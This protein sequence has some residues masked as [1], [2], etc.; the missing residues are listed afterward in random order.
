MTNDVRLGTVQQ[1][2]N[3]GNHNAF[4]DL[5]YFKD[6]YYLTFRNCPDGHMLYTTSRIMVL[7]STDAKSWQVVHAFNVPDRDVR[8]P[9]FLLF[10]D[11]LFVCS[12]TWLVDPKDPHAR[13]MNE[14]QGYW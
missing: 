13:S 12:G 5:C 8:D 10:K 4:T 6:R 14:Q 9:H 2:Y 1:V 3:D 11:K 7:T